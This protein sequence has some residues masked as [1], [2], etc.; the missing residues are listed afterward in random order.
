MNGE[1]LR[2]IDSIHRE[3]DIDKEVLF[4]GLEEA[5]SSAVRKHFNLKDN[6]FI[7]INR[8]DGHLETPA[9]IPK[10]DPLTLGRIAAQT[11]KQV[12]IQK[13]REAERDV[14]FVDYETRLKTLVNGTVLR[15]EGSTLIVNLGRTEGVLPRSEQVPGETYRPGERLRAIVVDVRKKGQ[16]VEIILS[17]SHPDFVRRLFEME[18]PEVSEKVVEINHLVREPGFRTKVAVSSGD[19]RVDC[20]GA[21]VGVRGSRIKNIVQELNGEKIDIIR[22]SNDIEELITNALRP[23]EI[24]GLTL[25]SAAKRVVVKMAD[26]QLSLAIGKK[27]HNVRLAS[28]LCGWDINVG[29]AREAAEKLMSRIGAEEPVPEAGDAL[30]KVLYDAGYTDLQKLAAAKVEDL[31]KIEGVDEAKAA[32]LIE[33]ARQAVERA[34]GAPTGAAPLPAGGVVPAVEALAAGSDAVAG[35]VPAASGDAAAPASGDVPAVGEH[36][37]E[38]KLAGPPAEGGAAP[39]AK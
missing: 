3:K 11:A 12:I 21:C 26:D 29:G 19:S 7:T 17:R 34:Q 31:V 27:G 35:G 1:L 22:W 18:I 14:V 16:K 32:T 15:F 38:D 33:Q 8:E 9:G 25:D 30:M 5:L 23:A 2:I 24:Q 10:I 37:V 4:Q 39:S 28:R 20:V 13:I 6:V 36:P